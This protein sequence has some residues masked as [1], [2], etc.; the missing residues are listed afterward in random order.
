MRSLAHTRPTL[1]ILEVGA[2]TGGTTE[3]VLGAL[4]DVVHG[5]SLYATYTFTD[6]SAGFLP[7][8]KVRFAK[9]ST[10][11]DFKVFDI[12]RDPREQGF[13]ARGQ[14]LYDLI[15]ANNVIHATPNLGQTL[16][17]LRLLLKPNGMLAMTELCGSSYATN[18]LFGIFSGWW[19]GEND[20]RA[21]QPYVEVSRW[22]QELKAAGFDGVDTTVYA[23]LDV[24]RMRQ[25]HIGILIHS[26]CGGVGIAALQV[27]RMMGAEIYTTCGSEE[28]MQHLMTE[29]AIP[30]NR[31]FSSR[32]SSFLEVIMESTGGR[33]V[34][35][36]LNSLSGELM[37][38][39]WK[40]VA[41]KG[42]LLELG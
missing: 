28:K 34:S 12:T 26:A 21:E 11:M 30:R 38:A 39:S 2:G 33:G 4:T 29:Y 20:D 15:I 17:H 7:A 36:V 25:N 3:T 6:I 5:V 27:A 16:G 14:D 24:G 18:Y 23:M 42:T 32:D 35:L 40:C 1:R 31:I 19:L 9:A 41:R 10:H 22:D 13:Q 37:H 8:A